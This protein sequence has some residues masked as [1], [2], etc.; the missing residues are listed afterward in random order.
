MSD[1]WSAVHLPA[2]VGNLSDQEQIN[3]L[4]VT[5]DSKL[6]TFRPANLEKQTDDPNAKRIDYIF[7]SPADVESAQVVLTE[8]IEVQNISYS[9][10]FGLS[11]SLQLPDE[12]RM[13]SAYLPPQLFNEI[14]DITGQY[15]MR[16]RR[17][18]AIRISHFFFSL[19][20]CFSMLVGI[21]FVV[22]NGVR[23][24]MLFVSTMSAWAGVVDGMIGY[25]WGR[26]EKRALQEFASEIDLARSIYAQE[27]IPVQLPTVE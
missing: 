12:R 21:W 24:L 13:P 3:V 8:R 1:T 11:V 26:W 19:A 16:E 5:C 27:G 22:R 17:Q 18:C 7:T 15:C 6:N 25:I 14:L 2:V 9:D 10:H 23:F 4:G 20:L